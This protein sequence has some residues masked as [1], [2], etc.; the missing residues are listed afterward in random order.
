MCNP[1]PRPSLCLFTII[2]IFTAAAGFTRRRLLSSFFSFFGFG[3]VF[4]ERLL[5]FISHMAL[6]LIGNYFYA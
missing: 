2:I 1:P 6:Q 3:A 4:F 5:L